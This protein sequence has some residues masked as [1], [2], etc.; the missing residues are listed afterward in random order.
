MILPDVKFAGGR[1]FPFPDGS[2]VISSNLTQDT[3]TG[4]GN[5]N[6]EMFVKRFTQ[7]VDSGYVNP[8]VPPGEFNTIMPWTMYSGMKEEDLRAIYAYLKTIEPIKNE[9]IKFTASN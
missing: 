2:A 8:K 5:W 3:E 6:E 1:I 9:V 7:Y 4:I